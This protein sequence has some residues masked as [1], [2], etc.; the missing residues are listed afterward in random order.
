VLNENNRQAKQWHCL[1]PFM[2]FKRSDKSVYTSK[3]VAE[4]ELSNRPK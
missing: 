1:N 4:E 3:P 2:N